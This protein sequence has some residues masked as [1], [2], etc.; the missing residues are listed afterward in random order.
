M[1][2]L[3]AIPTMLLLPH[4]CSHLFLFYCYHCSY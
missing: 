1:S 2:T 4:I 3:S